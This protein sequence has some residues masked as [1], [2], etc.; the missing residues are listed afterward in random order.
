MNAL[1]TCKGNVMNNK[2]KSFLSALAI[3]LIVSSCAKTGYQNDESIDQSRPVAAIK[4]DEHFVKNNPVEQYALYAMMSSNAYLDEKR[5]HFPIED[6]GWYRVDLDGNRIEVGSDRYK[7]NSY[8]PKTYFGKA[9]SNLQYDIWEH[10][11]GK[12]SIIS[13]KGT[14]ENIDWLNCN[15]WLGISIPYKSAKKHYKKYR[16]RNP[17]RNV[18]LTGHSCG[19]GLALSVSLWEKVDAYVFNTSPR[20]ADGLENHTNSAIRKTVFQNDEILQKIRGKYPKF[21][22][23]IPEEDR[24]QT[25][26]DYNGNNKHRIEFLAEGVLR[27]AA[28]YTDDENLTKIAKSIVTNIECN[29]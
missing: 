11:D 2:R 16:D 1:H 14:D 28:K 4:F 26:F 21:L 6:L 5:T 27:C 17:D 3:F 20:V 8:R 19:G 22:E 23:K 18:I 29:F 10:E 25:N 15:L 24:V 7:Y 13:F 9:L 12:R